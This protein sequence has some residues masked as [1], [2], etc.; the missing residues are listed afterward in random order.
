MVPNGSVIAYVYPPLPPVDETETD[1]SEVHFKGVTVNVVS[2]AIAGCPTTTFAFAVQFV[3]GF[4]I[5][6]VYVPASKLLNGI[7]VAV[8]PVALGIAVGPVTV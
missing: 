8:W 1:P 3:V 7:V 2:N 6:I 5:T 4:V